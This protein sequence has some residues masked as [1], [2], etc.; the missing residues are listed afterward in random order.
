[1]KGK[2]IV[3]LALG[4]VIGLVAVKFGVDAIKSAQ[5]S[6][7]AS[8][9][10]TAVRAKLD[11]AAYQEITPELLEVFTTTDP[12]FAPPGERMEKVEDVSGRVSAKAIP[13]RAPVLASMLAPPGT[14]AGMVGR[15]PPGF[16]AIAVKIDEVG[17]AGYHLKPGDWV[18]VIVVMDVQASRG[19]VKET[20]AEVIL[21]H[22]QV[23]AIGRGHQ[24]ESASDS[25]SGRPAKSATLLVHEE[26]VPKLHLAGTRGKLTL[27]MR[28]ED[29]DINLNPPKATD[30]ELNQ[31][32][33]GKPATPAPKPVTEVAD[34][35]PYEEPIPFEVT[36]HR[37]IG[38]KHV[39]RIMFESEE[40]SQ[41]MEVASGP[42]THASA[43]M[44]S[45]ANR[46]RASNA[47]FRSRPRKNDASG[48]RDE[49]DQSDDFGGGQ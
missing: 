47:D 7:Q 23:A 46:R 28:G 10:I 8:E 27:A 16:R 18:D 43:A 29:D 1:M 49:S 30:T 21:Q 17:T 13:A 11:I 38:G 33:T 24:S 9:Q 14:P 32:L 45:T 12:Q 4:L 40:S 20:I 36:I 35:T 25:P 39:E 3:P 22:V 44:R 34:T 2:A 15:I 26:D 31:I 37:G 5:G 6:N 19:G 48:M 41:V 42:P